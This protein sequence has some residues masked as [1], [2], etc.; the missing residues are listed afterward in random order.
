MMFSSRYSLKYICRANNR[1][2]RMVP[3]G[4][5]IKLLEKNARRLLGSGELW[6][7]QLVS[8]EC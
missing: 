8:V 1:L 2:L 7:R 4:R 5:I 6:R 3:E